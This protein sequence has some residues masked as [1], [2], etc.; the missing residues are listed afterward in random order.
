[1][2]LTPLEIALIAARAADDKKATD[3]ELIDLTGSTDVC[4]YFLICTGANAR[5]A[6]AVVEE[7]QE[8]VRLNC[9]IKPFSVE[10]RAGLTW[11]LLDYGSLVVHV[12]QPEA[13]EFYRLEKLW[14]DAPRVELPFLEEQR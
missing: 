14:G 4:D 8:K 1:M 2:A 9:S 11:V 13:R 3:I 7:I 5:L 12:F 6:D 10:G